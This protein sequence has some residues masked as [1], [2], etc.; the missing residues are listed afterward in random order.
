MGEKRWRHERRNGDM[1]EKR[2]RRGRGDGGLREM[3]FGE[4]DCAAELAGGHLV[5]NLSYHTL[6][7]SCG[8]EVQF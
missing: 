1:R 5:G 6:M 3:K 4:T 2:W 8:H 7:V